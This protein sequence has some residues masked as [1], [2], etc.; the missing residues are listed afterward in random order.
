MD[1][2][3]VE[4]FHS[5]P[6][7]QVDQIP[8]VEEIEY[9]GLDQNYLTAELIGT[10]IFW[11]I[12]AGGALIAILLNLYRMPGWLSLLL[13]GGLL[14]LVL[15]SFLLT[16][17]GFRRKMYALRQRDIIYKSGLIWRRQTALPFNR[18]QHAEV[19]QGPIERLFELSKIK[20][21][22]AGG[23]SSDLTIAGLKHDRAQ[24]IKQFILQKTSIDEEE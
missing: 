22:T 9:I 24:R 11:L 23:S 21:Y 3:Q 1:L 5:N 13:L 2:S 6:Q 8:S 15:I 18:V 14:G 4:E 17:F 7:V 12:F 16:I 19:Q 10:A 20:V